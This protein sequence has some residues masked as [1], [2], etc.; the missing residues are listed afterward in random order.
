MDAGLGRAR[1]TRAVMSLKTCPRFSAFTS[2]V[3]LPQLFVEPAFEAYQASQGDADMEAMLG[4]SPSGVTIGQPLG[5]E[6]K[7]E[8]IH[9]R[10]RSEMNR[11]IRDRFS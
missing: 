6:C 11:N 10:I 4:L 3:E 1:V 9:Q 2:D 8:Q 5:F 7:S